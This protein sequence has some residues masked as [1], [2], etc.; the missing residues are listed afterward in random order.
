VPVLDLRARFGLPARAVDPSE[1]FVIA[2]AGDR[3]VALRTDA[4]VGL[5]TV[6]DTALADPRGAV[7]SAEH[8]PAAARLPDG[9]VLIHDLRTFLSAAEAASLDRALAGPAEARG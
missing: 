5:S 2:E 7:P 6:D 4:V 8:V 1:H 3:T 9:L